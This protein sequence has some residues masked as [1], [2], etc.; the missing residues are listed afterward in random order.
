M[1]DSVARTLTQILSSSIT[2]LLMFLLFYKLYKPKYHNKTVY[3]I[4]FFFSIIC[5]VLVNQFFIKMNIAY[6]NSI[7]LFVYACILKSLMFKEKTKKTFIYNAIYIVVSVFANVSSVLLCSVITGNDFAAI[8]E[9]IKC[10]LMFNNFYC[11]FM[12][13]VWVIFI[14][15][16]IKGH[17]EAIKF[18]QLLLIG[19]FVLFALFVEYNFTIRIDNISDVITDLFILIGF[20][21]VS[22]Y[23][24]YVTGEIARAYKDKYEYELMRNQSQLQLE[25]YIEMN[26]R[27]EKSRVVMHDIKKHLEVLRSLKNLDS[28]QAKEYSDV[29]EKEVDVLFEGFQC[30]NKILSVI[31]SQKISE[32]ENLS[33]KV[34][35]KIEDIL[36]EFVN[37]LDLTAIFANLWDNAIEACQKIKVEDRFIR[38]LI[39][40]VNDFYVIYFENSFNGYV[41]KRFDNIISTKES[42]KGVGLSIIKASAEKYSGTFNVL[43]DD[44]VFKVEILLPIE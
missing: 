31:M 37:D 4:T 32:A 35:T 26:N 36:F 34:E 1:N 30:S 24:V 29:I 11:M 44:T 33:I 43:N 18:R 40:R 12:V 19:L 7:F 9:D 2:S 20:L 21:I 15:V 14:S 5:I 13:I 6:F 17:L 3:I 41:K 42:H 39:G 23:I 38:I 22:I 25:H 27:Y 28:E 16:I 8:S 10:V